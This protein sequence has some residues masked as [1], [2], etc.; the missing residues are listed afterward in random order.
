[1]TAPNKR[2]I[3]HLIPDGRWKQ[4]AEKLL[5]QTISGA[6]WAADAT[7]RVAYLTLSL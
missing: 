4:G 2:W 7:Q 3:N 6:D 5:S 1:M